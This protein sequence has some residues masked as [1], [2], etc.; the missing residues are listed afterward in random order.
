MFVSNVYIVT[1]SLANRYNFSNLKKTSAVSVSV[2][3]TNVYTLSWYETLMESCS[4]IHRD[5]SLSPFSELPRVPFGYK[6][7]SLCFK[8]DDL[9]DE[10]F[11]GKL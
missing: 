11:G 3:L 2:S 4:Q 9:Q 7:L 1:R 6:I 5:C 8:L 10:I